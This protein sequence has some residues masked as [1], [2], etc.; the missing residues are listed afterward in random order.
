MSKMNLLKLLTLV[1]LGTTFGYAQ[2]SRTWVSG[3]GDD[4]TVVEVRLLPYWSVEPMLS[5]L[6]PEQMTW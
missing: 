1:L 3:V 2:A 5:S 6:R 4:L